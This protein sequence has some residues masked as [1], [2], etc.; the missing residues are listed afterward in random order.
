MTFL[1]LRLAI[2]LLCFYFILILFSHHRC[3]HAFQTKILFLKK[4]KDGEKQ[5][6][7]KRI[8]LFQRKG[9][10]ACLQ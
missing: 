9:Q 6:K 2:L 8:P 5:D 10:F 4:N 7:Q 1:F 3:R